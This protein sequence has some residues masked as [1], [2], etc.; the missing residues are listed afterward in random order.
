MTYGHGSVLVEKEHRHR[1]TDY[2][3]AS[4]NNAILPFYL[5]VI[6]CEKLHN[7]RGSTGEK[8]V[9]SL[10][11]LTRIVWVESIH[12]L[13]GFNAEKNLFNVHSFRNGKLDENSVY[14]FVII[15]LINKRKKLFLCGISAHFIFFGVKTNRLTRSA[16]ITNVYL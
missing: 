8:I 3:R 13:F 12:V 5:H 11:Y 15:K 14:V 4:H 2:I 7:A 1:L 10:H 9:F 6:T 16:L